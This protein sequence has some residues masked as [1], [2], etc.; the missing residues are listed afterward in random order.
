[1]ADF[2]TA[3]GWGQSQGGF[4]PVDASF[5]WD[6]AGVQSPKNMVSHYNDVSDLDIGCTSYVA[7]RE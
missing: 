1:M 7:N 2:H 6:Y 3:S 5:Q 4:S